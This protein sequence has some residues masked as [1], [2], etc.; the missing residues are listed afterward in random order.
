MPAELLRDP[1][2][3][4]DVLSAGEAVSEQRVG[5]GRPPGQVEHGREFLALAVR[6]GEALRDHE[7]LAGRG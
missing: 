6:K 1:A 5:P 4:E 2:R 3:R 7:A